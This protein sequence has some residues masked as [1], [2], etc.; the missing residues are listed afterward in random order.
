MQSKSANYFIFL[1]KSFLC[2][3][4][5]T[6]WQLRALCNAC[7]LHTSSYGPDEISL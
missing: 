6:P 3:I 7:I 2:L 1:L 4:A 5:V